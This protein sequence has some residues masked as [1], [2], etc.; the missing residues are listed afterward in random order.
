MQQMPEGGSRGMCELAD[1]TLVMAH[2]Q[3]RALRA[4]ASRGRY[5]AYARGA[6]LPMSTARAGCPRPP[7]QVR[8]PGSGRPYTRGRTLRQTLPRAMEAGA[9]VGRLRRQLRRRLRTRNDLRETTSTTACAPT[10]ARGPRLPPGRGGGAHRPASW[11]GSP[12]GTPR[13]WRRAQSARRACPTSSEQR[14]EAG[15][16]EPRLGE[17][18]EVGY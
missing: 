14:E 5:R 7:P 13:R 8:H 6:P 2:F 15:D 4:R 12:P 16:E 11:A 18:G 1:N 3:T 9:P 10:A 17:V